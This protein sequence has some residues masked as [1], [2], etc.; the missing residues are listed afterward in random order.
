MLKWVHRDSCPLRVLF[1][2]NYCSVLF[3]QFKF[4][5]IFEGREERKRGR[6]I[7]NHTYLQV[8]NILQVVKIHIPK[9]Y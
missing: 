7:Q 6:E 1:I 8:V 9:Y 2:I 5:G 3:Q 4:R